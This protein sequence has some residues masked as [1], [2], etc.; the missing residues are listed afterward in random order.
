[1]NNI[2]N[3]KLKL[4][5]LLPTRE[6]LL[7]GHV[8]PSIETIFS[9]A[10]IVENAG[11]DSI[12]VGDSLTA[13]PRLEPLTMLAAIAART[14][15]VRLGTAVLLAALRNPLALAQAVGT[16]DIISQGRAILGAGVGGA[17]NKAQRQEWVNLG[18]EISTRAKRFEEVLQITKSLIADNKGKYSGSHFHLDNVTILPKSSRSSETPIL[19]ACHWNTGKDIQFRRAARLGDGFISI[20][21]YP[22]EY[23]LLC[24]KVKEY[25]E[26]YGRNYENM[27]SAF[28]MT[29][30]IAY[31][32]RKATEEANHFLH[33]YYGGNY[34]GDRWGPYGSPARIAERICQYREAGADTIIIRF[35][36]FKQEHQ[37]EML[38]NTIVPLL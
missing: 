14:K 5:I 34:W 16:L 26:Q 20:S 4:G 24:R 1:M 25:T 15:K 36:S 30:N 33:Q 17:F 38:L 9:M 21:D 27:E 11:L 2:N 12:W 31:D 37:L 10:D 28:Y 18:I 29:I 13:K 7:P 22:Q 32:E 8:G 23:G 19:I 35:A 6:I 3:N